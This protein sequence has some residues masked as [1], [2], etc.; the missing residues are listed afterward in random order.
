MRLHVR[1]MQYTHQASS[2][3]L[4]ATHFHTGPPS[5]LIFSESTRIAVTLLQLTYTCIRKL[6]AIYGQL[7]GVKG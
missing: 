2:A 1:N 4:L 6:S 7:V 3:Q 5:V